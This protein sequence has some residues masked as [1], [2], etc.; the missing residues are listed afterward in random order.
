MK[1]IRIVGLCVVAV[2]AFSAVAAASAMAENAPVFARCVKASPKNTGEYTEKACNTHAS[3]AGTGAYSLVTMPAGE[4]VAVEGK[5]KSTKIVVKGDSLVVVCTKDKLKGTL[6]NKFGRTGKL[7]NPVITLE[8]C[9]VEGHKT[10][11]CQ[12]EATGKIKDEPYY[13]E[14]AWLGEEET[15]PGMV[16]VGGPTFTCAGKE[17]ALNGVLIGTITNTSKGLTLSFGVNSHGEQED[18]SFWS[19]ES[20]VTEFPYTH[21]WTGEEGSEV[22]ATVTGSEEIKVKGISVR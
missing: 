3:P 6:E 4:T 8:K 12:N 5:S 10:E 17:I 14:D 16:L 13:G 18:S 2:F 20:Q 11:T 19:E 9:E 7:F 22:E 21:L 15:K 1:R